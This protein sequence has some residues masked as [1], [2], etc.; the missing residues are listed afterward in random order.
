MQPHELR[1][2]PQALLPR[3]YNK[4][5]VARAVEFNPLKIGQMLLFHFDICFQRMNGLIDSFSAFYFK[6][7]LPTIF[8][9]PDS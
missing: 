2:E 3:P 7:E 8:S 1:L 9:L 4:E 6:L 5:L